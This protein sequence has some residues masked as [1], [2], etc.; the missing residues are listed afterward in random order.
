MVDLQSFFTR[1]YLNLNSVDAYLILPRLQGHLS[2]P[3]DFFLLQD[4]CFLLPIFLNLSQ[5][6]GRN[7]GKDS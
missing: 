3:Q 7:A 4:F 1:K 5:K 2:Y 6:E